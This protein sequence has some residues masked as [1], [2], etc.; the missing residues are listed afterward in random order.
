MS[1]IQ[2]QKVLQS[3]KITGLSEYYIL[4]IYRLLLESHLRRAPGGSET[5]Y[6]FFQAT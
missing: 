3:T 4:P 1:K 6:L 2:A 5:L